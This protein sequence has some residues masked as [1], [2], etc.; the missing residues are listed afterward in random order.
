[1]LLC[2]LATTFLELW[3]RKQSVLVWEWDLHNVDMDEENRPE[4]ETNATT[5]RMNPVTREKEPYMST[6]SRA[7]RFVI[8]GSAVLFMVITLVTPSLYIVEPAY[9]RVCLFQISVVLS[10]VLGTIIY[11]ISLVSVIYGGGGFFVKEHAKL[12]TTVTAALINLVVIMILTRV[13]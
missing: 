11:R 4:F 2:S 9:H 3:K 13:S 7:I 5:F 1:M 6:W 12:F 8:T 10:A